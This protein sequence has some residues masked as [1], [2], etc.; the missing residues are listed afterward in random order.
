[1]YMYII[2]TYTH[3]YIYNMHIYV[4]MYI[5]INILSPTAFNPPVNI[6]NPSAILIINHSLTSV[7]HPS[8]P[9]AIRYS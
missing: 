1:M 9:Q 6:Q 5:Y 7:M 2:Y 3:I 8:N 4:S